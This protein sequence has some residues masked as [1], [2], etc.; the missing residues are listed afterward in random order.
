MRDEATGRAEHKEW[1]GV[2]WCGVVW[3]GVEWCGV[4]WRGTRAH[5]RV[6]DNKRNTASAG[7]A[8]FPVYFI[9]SR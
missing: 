2:E 4:V 9:K 3:S 1:S 7:S 5:M 8:Q 6:L